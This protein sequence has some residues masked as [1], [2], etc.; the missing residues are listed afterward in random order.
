MECDGGSDMGK[1]TPILTEKQRYTITAASCLNFLLSFFSA[2]IAPYVY[3]VP[4]LHFHQEAPGV[5]AF[6]LCC[7]CRS[8]GCQMLSAVDRAAVG[9]SLVC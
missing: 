7:Q 9:R 5:A 2:I 1:D 6:R 4:V 3:G 8:D